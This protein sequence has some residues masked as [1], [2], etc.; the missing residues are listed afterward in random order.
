MEWCAQFGATKVAGWLVGWVGG[1]FCLSNFGEQNAFKFSK[2]A[3][4]GKICQITKLKN[5]IYCIFI[6]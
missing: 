1:T 5:I 4:I 3:P 2:M 6:N